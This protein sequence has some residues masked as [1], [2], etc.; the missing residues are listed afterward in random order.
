MFESNYRIEA[1][2]TGEVMEFETFKA[3]YKRLLWLRNNEGATNW[4]YVIMNLK[5]G[6]PHTYLTERSRKNIFH[7]TILNSRGIK[8]LDALD[9]IDDDKQLGDTYNNLR[10]FARDMWEAGY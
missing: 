7:L 2:T 8:I 5:T 3:A 4:P 1:R 9:L 10:N 6:K